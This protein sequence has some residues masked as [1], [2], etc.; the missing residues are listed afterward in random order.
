M[1]VPGRVVGQFIYFQDTQLNYLDDCLRTGLEKE[2]H[3]G[4]SPAEMH[5]RW[6]RAVRCN[7]LL[8]KETIFRVRDRSALVGIDSMTC[9]L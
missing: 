9:G 2:T 7:G 4:Q 8:A 6:I 1:C 5:D 3:Q